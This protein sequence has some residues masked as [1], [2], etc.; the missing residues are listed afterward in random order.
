MTT[1]SLEARCI[2]EA[3]LFANR[4]DMMRTLPIGRLPNS[5]TIAEIGVAYGDFSKVMIEAHRPKTFHAFD[6]FEMHK[7][8]NYMGRSIQDVFQ[9]RTHLEYYRSVLAD[10]PV[11]F[12]LK[13]L[14]GDSS[15][16]MKTVMDKSYD[17]IYVDGNHSLEGI[18]RDVNVATRKIKPG[19]LLIFNDYTHYDPNGNSRIGTVEVVNTICLNQGWKVVGF[20]FQRDMF[21]DIALQK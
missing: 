17:L 19:G 4:F 14:Q 15:T 8:K 2:S 11:E 18:W 3:Q 9:G 7:E 1:P 16:N 10:I 12:E 6:L 21:C 13:L 5:P 20:A